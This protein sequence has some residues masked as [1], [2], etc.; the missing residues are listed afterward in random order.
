MTDSNKVRHRWQEYTE[1]LYD[2][3][4]NPQE[5]DMHLEIDIEDDA[6]DH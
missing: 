2:K 1:D 6:K 4:N 3:N 5:E